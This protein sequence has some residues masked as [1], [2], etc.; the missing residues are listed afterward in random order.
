MWAQDNFQHPL[1]RGPGRETS[2]ELGT[3][4]WE[5]PRSGTRTP[6]GW[7]GPGRVGQ[8]PVQDARIVFPTSIEL[9]KTLARPLRTS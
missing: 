8:R 9:P 5:A 1:R 3:R 7:A 6:A 2:E 4:L